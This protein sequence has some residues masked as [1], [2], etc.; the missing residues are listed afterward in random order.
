MAQQCGIGITGIIHLIQIHLEQSCS[1]WKQRLVC[2][3]PSAV[4][5]WVCFVQVLTES[6][7]SDSPFRHGCLSRT[8]LLTGLVKESH[9][10]S[11]FEIVTAHNHG[12]IPQCW[13][14]Q[15]YMQQLRTSYQD[16]AYQNHS[17]ERLSCNALEFRLNKIQVNF[18]SRNK[19][20]YQ[21]PIIGASSLEQQIQQSVMLLAV[22]GIS[23]AN[24]SRA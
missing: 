10:H 12:S 21:S 2:D 20:S 18:T 23:W 9:D 8:W 15:E 7:W 24:Q 1:A 3:N 16:S 22:Q 4:S 19:H 5:P 13:K 11:R 14:D 6:I 17:G